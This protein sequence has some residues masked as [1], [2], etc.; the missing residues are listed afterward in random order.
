MVDTDVVRALLKTMPERQRAITD[1]DARK[2][3][4]VIGGWAIEIEVRLRVLKILQDH[5][6][7]IPNE[8]EV[9]GEVKDQEAKLNVARREIVERQVATIVGN[10]GVT[11]EDKKTERKR[12]RR[13]ER[14][15]RKAKGDCVECPKSRVRR[16]TPGSTTCD[17]CGK[18]RNARIALHRQKEKA[19]GRGQGG[20]PVERRNASVTNN[21]ATPKTDRAA[22]S[23]Q[24][25][26]PDRSVDAPAGTHQGKPQRPDT[27]AK[28]P[29]LSRTK[30]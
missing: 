26:R 6:V 13:L 25:P 15:A 27:S 9:I 19:R 24:S 17:E 29:F 11:P 14:D 23:T 22:A 28:P 16:A 2:K 5:G 18:R 21:E 30:Q 4:G 8:L 20:D 3:G 1:A 12:I 10:V 7:E